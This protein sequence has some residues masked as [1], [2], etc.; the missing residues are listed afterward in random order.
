M[1][2]FSDSMPKLPRRSGLAGWIRAVASR[3]MDDGELLGLDRTEFAEIARDLNLSPSEL[4]AISTAGNLSGD[5]LNKRMAEFGLSPEIVKK[6]H[7]EVSRDLERVCGMCSSKR[8]CANEFGQRGS[9]TRRSGYCPNTQTLQALEDE[10]RIEERALP[11][12]PACC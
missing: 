4:Y 7:P 10:S 2:I 1:T 5:L 6:Q 11:F 8:R 3:F 9:D 12:G